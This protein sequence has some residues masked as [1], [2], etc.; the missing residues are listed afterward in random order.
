MKKTKNLEIK[1]LHISVEGKEI[2]KGV[3]LTIKPG[4]VH[5]IM[6]PN[7]SGKSTFAQSLMGHPA[8]KVTVKSSQIKIG[9]T[10]ISQF[11]A[12]KRAREGL[13]LAFQTPVGVSGISV[14][15]LLKTA[16]ESINRSKQKGSNI[17][18]NVAS[19]W[20]FNQE[21]VKKADVLHI[22]HEFLRRSISEGFS[23]GEKKKLEMLQALTLNPKFAIFDEIDTGLDIDALKIVAQGI[24]I[25]KKEGTGILIITHYQRILKYISPD[26]V[27]VLMKGKI[28]KTGGPKLAE[29]LE[30]KGYDKVT[31]I[32]K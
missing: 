5:V 1:D 8:Y 31:S 25:L 7:G 14:A 26:V 28:V 22:P 9:D 3:S 12:D 18:T 6:G 11:E 32:N 19:V 29:A 20:Q 23:G 4:E 27:H 13:F 30:E 16:H 15:N 17:K 2:L 24:N 21:L 10:D